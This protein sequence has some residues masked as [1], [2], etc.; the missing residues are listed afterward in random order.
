MV[1]VSLRHDV[2]K[3]TRLYILIRYINRIKWTFGNLIVR[4]LVIGMDLG[5]I[6]RNTVQY[7]E[8][9]LGT[10]WD[11]DRAWTVELHILTQSI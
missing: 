2:Y 5:Y 3:I 6:N 10:L 7:G 1:W 8:W 4:G 9:G 11:L